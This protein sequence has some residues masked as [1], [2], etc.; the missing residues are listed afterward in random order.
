MLLLY[1]QENTLRVMNSEP[2]SP[3]TKKRRLPIVG[4]IIAATL[5]GAFCSPFFD[6]IT[7]T[8]G[9]AIQLK[10][11]RLYLLGSLVGVSIG[12]AAVVAIRRVRLP[13][14]F[15]FELMLSAVI[16]SLLF[17]N[18]QWAED[19]MEKSNEKFRARIEEMMRSAEQA[20]TTDRG[21]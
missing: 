15:F 4:V 10:L 5:C 1:L 20:S 8:H 11:T 18:V 21:S 2:D 9:P 14:A 3:Q 12:V 6:P 19:R 17:V 7:F 13:L 16:V